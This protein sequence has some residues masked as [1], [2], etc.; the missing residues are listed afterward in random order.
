MPSRRLDEAMPPWEVLDEAGEE[1]PLDI[2]V[3]SISQTLP[4]ELTTVQ[5]PNGIVEAMV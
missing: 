4:F 2:Y 5:E 3:S 1:E